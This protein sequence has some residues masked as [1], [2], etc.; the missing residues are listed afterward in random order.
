MRG[1][2]RGG[3]G[4]A[5]VGR[6]RA[7]AA[8]KRALGSGPA[9]RRLG[10]WKRA[11][12]SNPGVEGERAAG[13][14][15]RCAGGRCRGAAGGSKMLARTLLAPQATQKQKQKQSRPGTP[16]ARDALARFA[17]CGRE[18][19]QMQDANSTP[20]LGALGLWRPRCRRPWSRLSHTPPGEASRRCAWGMDG[21]SEAHHQIPTHPRRRIGCRCGL[22]RPCCTQSYNAMA[23]SG[24][25]ARGV[26][27]GCRRRR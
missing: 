2:A 4:R 21:R 26:P 16:H 22:G 9:K 13:S 20:R 1:D 10:G 27:A 18:F 12:V 3:K 14:S 24:Q 17:A 11:R 5:A 7:E 25:G 19:G 23:S 8:G 6:E 15:K